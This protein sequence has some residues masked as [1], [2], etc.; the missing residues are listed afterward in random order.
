MKVLAGR[1]PDMTIEATNERDLK[2]LDT[3]NWTATKRGPR[4]LREEL[5]TPEE[6]YLS[7]DEKE[8]QTHLSVIWPEELQCPLQK[9]DK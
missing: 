5:M 7:Q 2:S 4:Q 6:Y 9:R 8:L 1:E 3:I